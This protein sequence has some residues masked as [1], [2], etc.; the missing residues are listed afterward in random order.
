VL[1]DEPTPVET[2]PDVPIPMQLLPEHPDSEAG[3]VMALLVDDEPGTE[4]PRKGWRS[5]RN[6]VTIATVAVLAAGGLIGVLA[7]V[8]ASEAE[9]EPSS[10]QAG[11]G[12]TAG[13]SPFRG[14]IGLGT[15]QT[16]AEFKDVRV[17]RDWLT[18]FETNFAKDGV[19]QWKPIGGRWEHRGDVYRQKDA[20]A[21]N[22]FTVVGD[23]SW[24]DYTLRLKARKT[25]GAEGFFIPFRWTDEKNYF[26][27]NVGGLG[28]RH[29]VVERVRNGGKP[30]RVS[31]VNGHVETNKWYDLKIELTGP[32]IRCYLDGK[33]INDV[34]VK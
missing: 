29:H 11:V 20:E 34:E 26:V 14:K 32:R 21:R 1:P 23:A 8:M 33:L 3:S 27:W 7:G 30:A 16:A 10:P 15:W 25:G 2:P 28:N 9:T 19:A 31:Q 24:S 6:L 5:R 22:A 4:E 13:A 12:P 18:L 17:W